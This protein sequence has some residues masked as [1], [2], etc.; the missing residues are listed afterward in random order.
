MPLDVESTIASGLQG[1]VRYDGYTTGLPSMICDEAI[2]DDEVFTMLAGV[3]HPLS[4]MMVAMQG[5]WQW[6]QQMQI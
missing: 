6:A 4:P 1:I 3:S 5:H 2:V